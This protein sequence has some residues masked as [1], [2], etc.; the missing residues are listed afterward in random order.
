MA[1]T[2]IDYVVKL[3]VDNVI[4][5]M[6]SQLDG[7]VS[8]A[9]FD[10]V[11]TGA[12]YT[13]TNAIPF[14]LRLAINAIPASAYKA[15]GNAAVSGAKAVADTEMASSATDSAVGGAKAIGTAASAGIGTV[16]GFFKGKK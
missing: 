12:V 5:S 6:E 1:D 13:A 15:A 2:N 11:R 14:P 8:A 16:T 10:S 3:I 9:V 4:S 7:K